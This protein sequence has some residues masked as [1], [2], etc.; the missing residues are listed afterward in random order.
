MH[1]HK[2][3]EFKVDAIRTSDASLNHW[4]APGDW[5]LGEVEDAGIVRPL[6]LREHEIFYWEVH[7][8][9]RTAGTLALCFPRKGEPVVFGYPMKRGES[10]WLE[11]CNAKRSSNFRRSR[12]S[13]AWTR[14]RLVLEGYFRRVAKAVN[15]STKFIC[16]A[17]GDIDICTAYRAGEQK[18]LGGHVGLLHET[19]LVVQRK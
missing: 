12:L 3:V 9:L 1:R 16:F 8:Q 13:C 14:R 7:R 15:G 5:S 18:F 19:S 11:V 6:L 4:L 10:S 17:C 2:R